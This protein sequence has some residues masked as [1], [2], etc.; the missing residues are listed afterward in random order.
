MLSG[1]FSPI[2]APADGTTA[3]ARYDI[4]C[5]SP[6]LPDSRPTYS[7]TG[8]DCVIC[9][10]AIHGIEIRAPCNHYYDLSCVVDLFRA[11]TR[12]E[13]LFPP[14]CCRNP[15]PLSRVQMHLPK[16]LLAL[17]KEKE[18]EFGTLNRVYCSNPKCSRFLGPVS[19][20]LFR[21][22]TTCSAPAC[23]T[24]TC[25][26]CKSK[27]EDNSWHSCSSNDT[28]GAV[29]ALGK[30]AK[31]ARCPGCGQMIE[32]VVG[33]YHMTCRCKTEFCYMCAA[34]WKTCGCAQWDEDRLLAAAEQRV[35]AQ[36]AA[37]RPAANPA[38]RAPVPLL[39]R[40]QYRAAPQVPP[41]NITRAEPARPP[42]PPRPSS[43]VVV[44]NSPI[45]APRRRLANDTA[46]LDWS[47]ERPTIGRATSLTVEQSATLASTS[48]R[49]N[50][51]RQTLQAEALNRIKERRMASRAS[52]TPLPSARQS[53]ATKSL[54][55]VAEKWVSDRNAMHM[56][57]GSRT[58][59]AKAQ[60]SSALLTKP[61][62]SASPPI[63]PI[64]PHR[65]QLIRKTVAELRVNHDCMHHRWMYSK[66]GGQCETCH[67][68]LPLYLWVSC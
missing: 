34:R 45:S 63:A 35:D 10:D 30:N 56:A 29:L 59:T 60:G 53:N 28:D 54:H 62:P 27:V 8:H 17:F 48:Q 11:A 22:T 67:H 14:R 1:W 50:D 16:E 44:A 2:V 25:N 20:G 41:P 31:W 66:G 7:P 57:H 19:Q 37:E 55:D 12:D 13:S 39:R 49:A 38:E 46:R 68:C 6:S 61:R 47:R 9:Q 3:P 4:Y 36:L 65:Q 23:H 43:Q 26:R 5:L 18:K 52:S 51:N 42:H 33:C 32:L 24:R 21:S 40:W 15:I 58:D 64:D